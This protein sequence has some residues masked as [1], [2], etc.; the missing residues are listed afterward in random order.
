M[1][2]REENPIAVFWARYFPYWPVFAGLLV[3][4]LLAASLYMR[5]KTPVYETA[6][7]ILIKDEKKGTN[8]SKIV[9]SLDLLSSK[10]IIEN[11][12]EVI[13]S[14]SL[15]SEVV[16][17]LHLYSYVKPAS[18]KNL[19]LKAPIEVW[20]QNPE[21]LQE[22]KD[23]PFEYVSGKKYVM[24]DTKP[25][26]LNK[27]TSTAY[28]TLYFHKTEASSTERAFIFTLINPKVVTKDFSAR[29]EVSSPSKL[30][31]IINLKLKDTSPSRAEKV[32]NE[33]IDVYNKEALQD[34]NSLALNTLAIVDKRL[35]D[36]TLELDSIEKRI[37]S[38][39]STESAIDIGEQGKLF[40][41]GVS[42]N[43]QRMTEL[44]MELSGLEQVKGYVLS[45]SGRG[46]IVP[47]TIGI[48][49]PVLAQLVET[50]Y[51]KELEYERLKKTTAENN[52]TMLAIKDQVEKMK[53]GIVE[54]IESRKNVLQAG[55]RNLS[56]A[57]GAYTSVLQTIPKKEK[58]LVEI[59]RDLNIKKS[60]YSFLLQKREEAALSNSSAVTDSRVVDRAESSLKPVSPNKKVVYPVA[61]I[62][63]LAIAVAFLVTRE[64]FNKTILFRKEIENLTNIPV[65]GEIAFEKA[66]DPIML[67]NGKANLPA[68]QFRKLRASLPY[69]RLTG[70][71]KKILI[72]SSISGEG[73]SFI[74]ANF[75]MSLAITGKK[76]VL[77]ECDMANP[78]LSEKLQ[79]T[80]PIGFAD[81]L[82]GRAEPEDII[83]RSAR[84]ENLFFISAGTLPRNPSEVI[85]SEK[86]G[87]LLTY[88]ERF[89]DYVV[90]D[91]APTGPTSDAYTLSPLCDA[92]FFIIR[93][94]FT[95][96]LLVERL[97]ENNKVNNLKNV[98]IVFNGVGKRGFTG[99]GY[100]YGYGYA[101]SNNSYH[102]PKQPN[103][104]AVFLTGR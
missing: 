76:V 9:E 11:E 59:S 81:Y 74:A 97:D 32:L 36:L 100:G 27:W 45:N 22:V 14:R 3:L 20:V 18:H 28:G 55:K 67:G 25:I 16:K 63:A 53:P 5:F 46:S 35:E 7:T 80:Q 42:T 90:L 101:Y 103:K 37:Q 48:K 75:A 78:T 21:T 72:T 95:P 13:R 96:K 19:H 79:Q 8:E 39:R 40:L 34:K 52:P 66:D 102:Q 6:A 62:L 12:M 43:D 51:S 77:V 29:L 61:I 104:F 60:L 92:T 84:N 17:T 50:L 24:F 88:L 94:K 57:T 2:K 89:F 73:K 87:E 1:I 30:S 85:M 91:S 68:E 33:L 70:A 54:N 38:F 41:Q 98:A 58:E 64:V 56:A 10:K 47:S 4:S 99:E 86:V 15:M 82:L 49:D 26:L 93:H 44:N 69:L 71:R 83:K 23:I 31:S 65:I